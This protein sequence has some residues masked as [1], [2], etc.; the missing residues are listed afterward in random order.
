MTVT[1]GVVVDG[2]IVIRN[3][4][5]DGISAGLE[6]PDQ[7]KV[8][9][10]NG[11]TVVPGFIDA[12]SHLGLS[13]DVRSETDELVEPM[14]AEMQ[15]VDAFDPT[16][17]DL[18]K[19]VR[20]GVTAAMLSPGARNPVGG[21][22]AVAKLSGDGPGSWLVNRTAGVKFSFAND[23]LISDRRPTSLPGLIT[24]V[25]EH[26]D[27]AKAPTSGTTG[28]S[29]EVLRRI[30][31]RQAPAYVY[32][33]TL[34]EITAALSVIDQYNLRAVL[35]GGRYADEVAEML[36][37]REIPVIYNPLL[38]CGTDEDLARAGKLAAAG[39]KVAFASFAP[40]TCAGDLRTS[41]I[42]A[43]RYGFDRDEALKA[44]TLTPAELLGL[45]G[46]LGSIRKGRDADLVILDG[47]PLDP[48]SRVRTVMI[49]G[50]VVYRREPK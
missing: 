5:I 40:Q 38:V 13:L 31:R 32:A 2:V 42:L 27:Q 36:V 43:V 35:I 4:K 30:A 15:I 34:D 48:S 17:V 20:A 39:V 24:L 49:D 37:E 21:Q 11:M 47:D 29:A 22:T 19:A 8:I 25:R 46:R 28:P 26:L 44:V 50:R 6:V 7:A 23:A 10:A 41:A 18:A 45:A 9:D 14:A 12:H 33:Q 1:D 3:G 16:A